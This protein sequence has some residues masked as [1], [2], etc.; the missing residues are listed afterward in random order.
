MPGGLF[1]TIRFLREVCGLDEYSVELPSPR[2]QVVLRQLLM[3]AF[4]CLR[5]TLEVGNLQDALDI[6]QVGH[7]AIH[8]VR[9][10]AA[11]G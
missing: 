2:S 7:S 11:L 4:R 8:P 9:E 10:V 1:F 6:I 5:L 3:T